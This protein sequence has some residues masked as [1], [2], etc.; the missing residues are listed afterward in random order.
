MEEVF[1]GEY[2]F[3]YLDN[4]IYWNVQKFRIPSVITDSSSADCWRLIMYIVTFILHYKFAYEEVNK[5]Y[6]GHWN[7]CVL[8]C[9]IQNSIHLIQN[10]DCNMYAQ[11]CCFDVTYEQFWVVFRLVAFV[12]SKNNRKSTVFT[13]VQGC[14]SF[15][16]PPKSGV[17]SYHAQ[18]WTHPVQIFCWKLKIIRERFMLCLGTYGNDCLQETSMSL[19]STSVGVPHPCFRKNCLFCD[20]WLFLSWLCC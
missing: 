6:Y 1:Y 4:F 2:F 17:L 7:Y 9:C 3:K 13:E 15:L 5:Y 16:H 10:E 14:C 18:S 12:P 20:K 8:K 11:D 19:L